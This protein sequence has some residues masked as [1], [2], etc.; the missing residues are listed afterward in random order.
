MVQ[1]IEALIADIKS[2]AA[3]FVWHF[4]WIP[5]S[6][7]ARAHSVASS[8]LRDSLPLDWISSIL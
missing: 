7:N 2:W 5:R 4:S 8:A 6:S 3:S 1:N